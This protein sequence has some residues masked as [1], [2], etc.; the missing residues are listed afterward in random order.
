ME[1]ADICD[2][3]QPLRGMNEKKKVAVQFAVDN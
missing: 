1:L 2:F 3:G